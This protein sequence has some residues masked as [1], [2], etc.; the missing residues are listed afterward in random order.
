MQ[1]LRCHPDL[2]KHSTRQQGP[3]CCT[4]LGLTNITWNCTGTSG[5]SQ[6]SLPVFLFVET[7]M[8]SLLQ[9]WAA[10]RMPSL[11][12]GGLKKGEEDYLIRRRGGAKARSSS[13]VLTPHAA[14]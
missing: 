10:D 13:V 2:L 6:D 12:A 11:Q 4:G 1:V 5:Q 14:Y 9:G 7:T 8:L 3:R